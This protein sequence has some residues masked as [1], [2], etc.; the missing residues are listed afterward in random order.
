[1][2][3]VTKSGNLIQNGI[4]IVGKYRVKK[5]A[6]IFQHDG[7]RMYFFYQAYC[8]RE[9]IA[10]VRFSELLSCHRKWWT[11]NAAGKQVDFTTVF[12]SRKM[13]YVCTENIP[14]RLVGFQDG[15]II[16]FLLNKRDMRKSSPSNP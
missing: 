8:F 12:F 2:D 15:A 16:V 3:A 5:T 13:L 11:G 10:L 14:F 6:D 4:P 7:A 1:M 9:Q